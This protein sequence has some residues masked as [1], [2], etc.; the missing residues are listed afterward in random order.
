MSV[1]VN[2]LESTN[3]ISAVEFIGKSDLE[4]KNICLNLM[5]ETNQVWLKNINNTAYSAL[6]FERRLMAV[7]CLQG[8][9]INNQQVVEK[10]ARESNVEVAQLLQGAKEVLRELARVNQLLPLALPGDRPV[11]HVNEIAEQLERVR[12]QKKT[13]NQPDHQVVREITAMENPDRDALINLMKHINDPVNYPADLLPDITIVNKL[14]DLGLIAHSWEL[15]RL[16]ALGRNTLKILMTSSNDIGRMRWLAQN[17]D[18][19]QAWDAESYKLLPHLIA[20]SELFLATRGY[21]IITDEKHTVVEVYDY[22]PGE[23]IN[24]SAQQIMRSD[25]PAAV[26]QRVGERQYNAYW[27]PHDNIALEHMAGGKLRVSSASLLQLL[28]ESNSS[29]IDAAALALQARALDSNEQGT[30]IAAQDIHS[31]GDILLQ[32]VKT[33]LAKAEHIS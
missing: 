32:E 8:Y 14:L 5:A 25:R 28:P 3:R 16:T 17:I 1:L 30:G 15:P 24:H 11:P 4:I 21:L 33:F 27:A 7:A 2:S 10:M 29:M 18:N 12:A 9:P 26:I 19:Q 22:L 13:T 20:Q 31:L 6:S 23:G